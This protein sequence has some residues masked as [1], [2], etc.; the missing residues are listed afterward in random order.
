MLMCRLCGSS[1]GSNE[2][3]EYCSSVFFSDLDRLNY[4]INYQLYFTLLT[5]QT[6]TFNQHLLLSLLS[7]IVAAKHLLTQYQT[8]K[9]T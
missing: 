1:T 2:Q 4:D 6:L 3:G 5:P 9:S 8:T 7:I